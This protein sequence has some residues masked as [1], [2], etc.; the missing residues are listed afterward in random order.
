MGEEVNE[1]GAWYVCMKKYQANCDC[2]RQRHNLQWINVF[3]LNVAI[4]LPT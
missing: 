1:L 2:G 3:V 4:L